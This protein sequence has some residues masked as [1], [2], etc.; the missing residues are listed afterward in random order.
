[1]KPLKNLQ[2]SKATA[3]KTALV[4]VPQFGGQVMLT[5]LTVAGFIRVH[6]LN[7][8]ITAMKDID[9]VRRTGLLMCARIMAAMVDPDTGDFLL[10]EDQLDE[11]HSVINADTLESLVVVNGELNPVNIKEAGM[12]LEEK[13]S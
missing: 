5:E 1:M 6:R 10:T 13:K 12:S 3:R 7:E 2:L 4:D 9:V 11:F 8:K